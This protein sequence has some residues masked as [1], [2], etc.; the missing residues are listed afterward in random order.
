MSGSATIFNYDGCTRK[1][2][3]KEEFGGKQSR[4][5]GPR[6]YQLDEVDP[7]TASPPRLD[8]PA[9]AVSVEFLYLQITIARASQ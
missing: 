1:E 2:K 9:P 5:L 8:G 4:E 6:L 3:E 7:S